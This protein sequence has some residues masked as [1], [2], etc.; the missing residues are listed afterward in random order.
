MR[1]LMSEFVRFSSIFPLTSTYHVTLLC[2]LSTKQ[3]TELEIIKIG[4]LV[5]EI[6]FLPDLANYG[7]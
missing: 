5:L 6:L 4:P 1:N 2:Q 7:Y 3:I